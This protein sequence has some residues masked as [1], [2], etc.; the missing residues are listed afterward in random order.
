MKLPVTGPGDFLPD[1]TDFRNET[2]NLASQ[3]I[4]GKPNVRFRFEFTHDSGNNIYIDNINITGV[5][6]VNEINAEN[7]N[8]NVYPNPST[9][10]TYMDFTMTA[11][12]VANINVQ[13]AEGHID[14]FIQW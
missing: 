9:S 12:G 4:S 1:P 14:K 8:V 10:V 2:V 3:S 13:D 11:A 5:V 6:G 7:A